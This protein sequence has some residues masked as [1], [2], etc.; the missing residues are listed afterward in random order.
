ME[1]YQIFISYRRD[2]G[3]MLAGRL[4]DKLRTLGYGVFFDVESMRSGLF[5]TQI[6]E[7]ITLC[8]DVIVVLPPCG[9]DRCSDDNDWVR[10]EQILLF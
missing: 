3:D 8:K 9:L 5:N 4:A 10:K 2:G 6:L 1:N 7:A